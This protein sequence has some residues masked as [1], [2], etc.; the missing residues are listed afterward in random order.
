MYRFYLANLTVAGI[1]ALSAVAS[2]SPLTANRRADAQRT[3]RIIGGTPVA[4]SD[5][6]F[7][8][9]IE[10]YMEGVGAFSCT[11]SLIAPSV[12]LTAG[13]CTYATDTT[14][15]TASQI[16]VGF[17]H[18]RPPED[19]L[20]QG[21]SVSTIITHPEFSMDTMKNDIALLILDDT[22]STSEATLAKVYNGG[23]SAGSTITAAGFGVTDP[24]DQDSVPTQL[25]EVDLKTGTTSYCENI[26]PTYDDK[27][28]ICT[29]GTAGKDTCQGDSGGPVVTSTGSDVAI[30]GITSFGPSTDDNPEGLCA[31][32]GGSGYYTRVSAFVPWIAKSANLNVSDFAVTGNPIPS[33]DSSD[34][35]STDSNS[36]KA[37]DSDIITDFTMSFDE[38]D[39]DSLDSSHST[40]VHSG[41]I[42]TIAEKSVSLLVFGSAIAAIAQLV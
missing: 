13:H 32:A 11:G 24:Y 18:T 10:G 6:T 34:D 25:M 1:V 38:T 35:D 29:D 27:T 20:Y 3:P 22:I 17:T 36:G 39:T 42:R 40:S 8:A 30:L 33:D 16:Q 15:F 12:V 5:F 31:Q 14:M 26:W 28:Q 9:F 23:V 7:I 4:S 21:H 41:N 19:T 37:G 2:G